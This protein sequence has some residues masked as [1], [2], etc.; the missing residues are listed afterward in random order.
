MAVFRDD[1]YFKVGQD[2]Y[3]HDESSF[4]YNYVRNEKEKNLRLKLKEELF[5]LA[6]T[7]LSKGKF[8]RFLV[9]SI[10]TDKNLI[11]CLGK[12]GTIQEF[13]EEAFDICLE[14]DAKRNREATGST[15]I[16]DVDIKESLIIISDIIERRPVLDIDMM[17]LRNLA[18]EL[19]DSCEF[20]GEKKNPYV[21]LTSVYYDMDYGWISN[22]DYI[23]KL[24][25][26]YIT[27]S[28]YIPG[29]S[30]MS[31]LQDKASEVWGKEIFAGLRKSSDKLE[32]LA[33]LGKS[34]KETEAFERYSDDL[35][36]GRFVLKLT[37]KTQ[38][39]ILRVEVKTLLYDAGF[40]VESGT[41]R[42]P[43]KKDRSMEILDAYF[44][45][46]GGNPF[47]G[48]D[49]NSEIP[50]GYFTWD[51]YY[52]A[53]DLLRDSLNLCRRDK[54]RWNILI[55]MWLDREVGGGVFL[56]GKNQFEQCADV[57]IRNNCE[58][59]V[60]NFYYDNSDMI[61][62][63][64]AFHGKDVYKDAF[65]GMGEAVDWF[66]NYE[67]KTD[68]LEK[69]EKLNDEAPAEC[70]DIFLK[71]FQK[72]SVSND[73]DGDVPV[74]ADEVAEIEAQWDMDAQNEK[75]KKEARSDLRRRT[76]KNAVRN[77]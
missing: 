11:T 40:S 13:A 9:R 65:P 12:L 51:E 39:E 43:R 33:Q 66:Q 56:I 28:K 42:P 16:G 15:S 45:Y 36:N 17:T 77:K 62:E 37:E 23:K 3:E 6:D 14:N 8:A 53:C 57:Y 2:Y 74:S 41:Y 71:F 47:A 67:Y 48:K 5:C 25:D 32:R 72:S 22:A 63:L 19:L 60:G 34:D 75:K 7:P 50:G 59:G 31:V 44:S 26:F 1:F 54:K 52:S 73:I 10:L 76:L 18:K 70:P 24:L 38:K 55:P 69:Y 20:E 30:D 61:F 35:V 46:V 29:K 49:G 4:I 64:N 27:N 21:Q 68:M 58:F